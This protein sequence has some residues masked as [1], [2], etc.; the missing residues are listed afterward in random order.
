M[1]APFC[2]V[3]DGNEEGTVKT[4]G[5]GNL[6]GA[7]CF[8]PPLDYSGKSRVWL[9]PQKQMGTLEWKEAE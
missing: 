5:A 6:Y 1:P 4:H 2:L 7:G 8:K 3:T 9:Y